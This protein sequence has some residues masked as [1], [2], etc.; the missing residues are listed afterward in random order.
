MQP[1]S[2]VILN[3]ELAADIYLHKLNVMAPTSFESCLRPARIRMRGKSSKLAKKYG[4]SAKTVRDIWNHKSW[5]KATNHLWPRNVDF[6]KFQKQ[7]TLESSNIEFL[8]QCDI[9]QMRNDNKHATEH[10][11]D[12]SKNQI[13]EFSDT[14]SNMSSAVN[15]SRFFELAANFG[16]SQAQCEQVR[17]VF[18]SG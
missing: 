13:N 17:S 18:D 15:Y 10:S 11:E 12:S 8:I 14:C 7:H 16:S 1:N 2:R 9:H 4:V 6:D 3:S 5:I